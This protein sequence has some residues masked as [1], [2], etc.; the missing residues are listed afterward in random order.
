MLGGGQR[1]ACS[2]G[3]GSG[4]ALRSRAQGCPL[5]GCNTSTN[6]ACLSHSV[7]KSPTKPGIPP[8]TTRRMGQPPP[9]HGWL[10]VRAAP[11][12]PPSQFRAETLVPTVLCVGLC[13]GRGHPHRVSHSRSR[14][15]A[16]RWEGEGKYPEGPG[17]K[18]PK[19]SG[20]S[21]PSQP[22]CKAGKPA[23]A[24]NCPQAHPR[25]SPPSA[26]GIYCT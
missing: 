26:E 5:L 6:E 10:Q 23:P 7:A 14:S 20:Q 18:T 12:N 22:F 25:Y 24:P 2:Q 19:D 13:G 11:Q 3:P 9:A 17:A 21:Q 8:G 1:S 4:L 16:A 15:S